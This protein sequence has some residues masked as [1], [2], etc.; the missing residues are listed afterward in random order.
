MD[1]D[2]DEQDIIVYLKLWPKHFVSS[3][4]ICRRAGGKQRFRDDPYW[5]NQPL[6]RLVEKHLV[7]S[8]AGG[9]Y[10]LFSADKKDKS[11]K[12]ISPHLKKILEESGKKFEDVLEPEQPEDLEP[13]E[14]NP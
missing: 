3:R 6:K 1:V 2:A 11:K 10:R 4:E 9:H 8:D 14:S 5:A 7:E 13:P 12:W